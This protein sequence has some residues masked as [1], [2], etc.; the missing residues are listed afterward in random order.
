MRK[1]LAC[2]ISAAL[3]LVL[4]ACTGPADPAPTPAPSEAPATPAPT[5]A[6]ATPEPTPEPTAAPEPTPEPT[7]APAPEADCTLTASGREY[8]AYLFSGDLTGSGGT[9]FTCILPL[10]EVT[11]DYAHNAWVIRSVSEPEAFLELSFIAGADV[12][13]L[14]PGFMDGY[15]DFTG[16]EFSEAAALGRVRGD[17]GRVS[18]ASA[19]LRA[20]GW[21]LDASGGTVSAALVCPLGAQEAEALLRAVLDTFDLE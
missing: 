6:P 2:L 7:P 19:A 5:A 12:E 17:V 4:C 1:R 21:L 11:A 9:D 18:A 10:E 3:L 13:T 15:L 20:E 8:P 14:L 16:I